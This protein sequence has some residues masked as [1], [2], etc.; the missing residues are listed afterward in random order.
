MNRTPGVGQILSSK[1]GYAARSLKSGAFAA[2]DRVL[3]DRIKVSGV[4]LGGLIVLPADFNSN[5]F[6][7]IEIWP[8]SENEIMPIAAERHHEIFRTCRLK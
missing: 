1:G 2:N 4:Y 3:L 6:C 8:Q 5:L 7:E